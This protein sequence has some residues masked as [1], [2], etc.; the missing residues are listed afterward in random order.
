M[1]ERFRSPRPDRIPN[2]S[3]D[4]RVADTGGTFRPDWRMQDPSRDPRE[5]F[6]SESSGT[7]TDHGWSN[8]TMVA[9]ALAHAYHRRKQA[10]PQ[11][12]DMRHNQSDLAGGTDLYD[13][14]T[15]WENWD[16][17]V[18][19]IR[20]GAGWGAV[21]QAHAEGRAIIIQGEGN[22]PGSEGFDGSHACCIGI[23]TNSDGKWLWGDPLATGWQ[24]VTA[25]S[26]REWA[27]RLNA[28]I[29]FAVSGV[30]EVAE[31][32][33]RVSVT[34][35][36]SGTAT[37]VGNNHSAIQLADGEM[38]ATPAGQTARIY[39]LGSLTEDW[40]SPAGT[41][42]TAGTPVVLR[43]TEAAIWF[44]ADVEL[45]PDAAAPAEYEKVTELYIKKT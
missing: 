39:A 15:A 12:G 31:V 26:I 5:P 8:C 35:S 38:H 33:I 27:Q 13:A 45:T 16:D 22:V 37:V 43:G 2:R 6:G 3:F 32:G 21:E 25:S 44:R 14:K 30:S 10:G 4:V 23:E 11:G 36:Y 17:A 40:K 41:V 19:S 34:D 18:L 1:I 20:S 28:N 24:W 42:F 7:G 29:L 9:A